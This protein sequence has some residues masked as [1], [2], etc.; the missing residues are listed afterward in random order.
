MAKSVQVFPCNLCEKKFVRKQ[1]LQRHKFSHFASTFTCGQCGKKFSRHDVLN[2]HILIVH[3]KTEFNCKKC[4]YATRKLV[5]FR[6]HAKTHNPV[7][8]KPP[9]PQ[10]S[11]FLFIC[12]FC[13]QG[14]KNYTDLEEHA[15][16][17]ISSINFKEE[18][19]AF[20][21]TCMTYARHYAVA[22]MPMSISQFF[23]AD[24]FDLKELITYEGTVKKSFKFAL[25][26]FV[27]MEKTSAATGETLEINTVKFRT[28]QAQGSSFMSGMRVT[29]ILHDFWSQITAISDRYTDLEGSGWTFSGVTQVNLEFGKCAPLCGG[30]SGQNKIRKIAGR[31]YLTELDSPGNDCFYYAVAQTF[32]SP[33]E[34][35]KKEADHIVRTEEIIAK[36][37]NK[38]NFKM[39]M[40]VQDIERFARLNPALCLNVILLDGKELHP[41]RVSR[42]KDHQRL[43]NLLLHP[44]TKRRDDGY[45]IVSSVSDGDSEYDT[46]ESEDDDDDGRPRLDKRKPRIG[47]EVNFHYV[48]IKNIDAFANA[49]KRHRRKG[50]GKQTRSKFLCINCMNCFTNTS[51]LRNHIKIC[52]LFDAQRI[53]VPEKGEKLTF[54]S[55][56]ASSKLPFLGCFDFE[57]KMVCPSSLDETDF[58]PKTEVLTRQKVVSYSLLIVDYNQ[59]I[60]FERTEAHEDNALDLFL[61][62]LEEANNIIKDLMR[63]PAPLQI[64]HAAQKKFN[65]SKTCYMCDKPFTLEDY[66]VH[67]HDHYSGKFLGAAHNT[68]NLLRREKK[69]VPLYCHNFSGFD[70]HFIIRLLGKRDAVKNLRVMAYNTEKIRS[71]SFGGFQLLDSMHFVTTGL[72]SCIEDMKSSG[73]KFDFLRSTTM[74]CT[75]EKFNLLTQ[76]GQF[77]YEHLQSVKQFREM[78]EFPSKDKFDSAL[79]KSVLTD[80]EYAHAKQVYQVFECKNMID[81]MLLYNKLDVVLLL[82]VMLSL[83]EITFRDFKLDL[84]NFISLPQMALQVRYLRY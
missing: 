4:N 70:S 74:A 69:T 46:D 66:A 72:G 28:K 49:F 67:D 40:D 62:A 58:G 35:F 81:Y 13:C 65:E 71:L 24:M 68:C 33:N 30:G 45:T 31:K 18:L 47:F 55:Q 3:S 23:Q 79:T 52:D 16:H 9:P 57:T 83:R 11:T 73:H 12:Q 7:V 64:S 41:L 26:M 48:Y 10:S 84:V 5:T 63:I 42:C 20:S 14:F 78:T 1:G 50:E 82:E 54:T 19:T 59:K 17:H 6:K 2:Q 60:I 32:I 25:I 51:A 43:V 8:V 53:I 76:K 21:K 77:P 27:L 38:G 15:K 37:I 56:A 75:D 34:T 39:P 44:S 36:N 22:E 29:Q 80:D 61:D